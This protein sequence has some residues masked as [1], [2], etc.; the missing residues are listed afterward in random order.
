MITAEAVVT[1]IETL[2][3]CL[4]CDSARIQ[5]LDAEYNFYRCD[6]CGYVFDNPRPT[7]VSIIRFYSA[8]QKYDS[9]LDAEDSRE[10]LWK[11]RLKKLLK[12]AKRGNLL[13]V[14]TGTGQ[15][16][17]LAKPHFNSVLGTEVSQSGLKIAREK[18]GLDIHEGQV[19][20]TNLP[21]DTFNTITLFHALEHVPDPRKTITRCNELLK[22]GGVLLVCV[23]NDILAWT[24]KV[25]ILGKKLGLRPFRKFSPKLGIPR[26]MSSKEIHLSHFTPPVLR[27]LLEQAGLEVIEE[28]IDP[29]YGFRGVKQAL[30]SG[31]F[32]FHR[33]FFG[34]TRVNRYDTI[35]MMARKGNA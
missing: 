7:L 23:P 24:S 19:E 12:H 28:S 26:V 8:P 1:E 20:D 4:L 10:E 31:Y 15:F 21:K 25:K 13:D 3:A 9:W 16:L 2:S 35:W 14:G 33:L 27:R 5:A 32:A 18:Y 17:N 11:R 6:A 30:H 34:L 22:V 29:Y